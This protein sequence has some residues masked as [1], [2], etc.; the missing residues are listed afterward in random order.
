[1]EI[2]DGI[3]KRERKRE[4]EPERE[5]ERERERR[6]IGFIT[7]HGLNEGHIAP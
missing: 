7:V 2:E 1:M 4:R 5:R 6:N 3:K